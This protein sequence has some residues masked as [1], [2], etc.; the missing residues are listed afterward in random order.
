VAGTVDTSLLTQ[1]AGHLADMVRTGQVSS[2]EL[3]EASLSRI[4]SFD[5][6]INAFNTLDAERALGAADAIATDDE[7]PF[8][9]VPIAIKDL[10]PVDGV[11][12]S[13][14]SDLFDFTPGHD[15]HVVR[16]I[17]DAGFVIVGVTNLPELGIL[18]VTEPRRF[19]ECRNPWDETR[20]PGGSSGGSAAAVA[21]GMVPI[22]HGSD[23]G[24]SIRIP[25]AC[26]GLVG[27]K[28]SRG[29]ISRGP[30]QGD[31]FLV[32]DGVLS[33]GVEDTA[34]MLD[35]LA[36]YE[37]G[38]ATWAPA[39]AE[40]YGESTGRDPGKLTIGYTT[41]SP[42]GSE[43]ESVTAG[44]V[45]QAAELLEAQG[46][47]LQTATPP[48]S[49]PEL[50]QTFTGIWAANIGLGVGTGG[51]LAGRAPIEDDV[52]PLTWALY[53]RGLAL[54]SV[55]YLGAMTQLHGFARTL[56]GW[57]FE[58]GCDVLL[59]P[60]LGERPVEHGV[61][62]H[63]AP[64]PMASFARSADFTPFT[65]LW[66]LTGQPAISLP[67]FHG[68]DGLPL[69]VQLVGRPGREDVLLSL[70]AQLEAAQPWAERLPEL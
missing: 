16:R 47:Q 11:P 20:T 1:S 59:T 5:E 15:S 23:G 51:I 48:W 54:D 46:H 50:L 9:G 67:L 2:R 12:F 32:T 58:S 61:M 33:R 43:I 56:T 34:L 27:L 36:G 22:A 26:C 45:G 4:E 49:A 18:P 52:E 30:E 70:A 65:A 14:G 64:D 53:Q 8:A 28:P 57:F 63:S 37:P 39:P 40:P 31:S 24:G 19:G 7:R 3:V 66:N 42:L 13:Y 21:A 17:R 41:E 38:D 55:S 6:R 62:Y 35:V 68:D 25:A 29:R 69:G 10:T 60:A 44:A